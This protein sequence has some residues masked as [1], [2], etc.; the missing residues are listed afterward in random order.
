MFKTVFEKQMNR[1]QFIYYSTGTCLLSLPL[2]NLP[3][4]ADTRE[5]RTGYFYDEICLQHR[6]EPGHPESAQRLIVLQQVMESSGLLDKLY[7]LDYKDDIEPWVYTIHTPAHVMSIRQNYPNAHKVALVVTGG[8]LSAVDAV[9]RHRVRNAFCATRPPGH[10]AANTGREEGFCF[11][12]HVAIAA[13][14]AQQE[15][16]LKK[17]L[18]VD[19]DYHHGNGT[20]AAFYSDPD[21]LFF[22]THDFYAYPGTG[23]PARTGYGAGKGYNINVHLDCGTTDEEIIRVFKEKLLP[24]VKGFRPELILISAGFDSRQDDLLGCF[25]ITDQGFVRL[26]QLVMSLA[27]EYCKGR[28]VSVLEGGYNLAGNA[29]AVIYHVATLAGK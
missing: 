19:W 2:I 7:L 8:V 24:A 16:K 18:I 27:D 14:Y 21:I 10:H 26:T 28:L 20:E 17:I 9:C 13:R 3:G 22:S 1:R 25:N 6:L 15:H 12:N 4:K 5:Y 11:Y 23:D 29:S